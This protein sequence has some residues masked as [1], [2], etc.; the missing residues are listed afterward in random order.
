MIGGSILNGSHSSLE[1]RIEHYKDEE[2]KEGKRRKRR[3]NMFIED[4]YDDE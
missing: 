3:S 1:D 2:A 4:N